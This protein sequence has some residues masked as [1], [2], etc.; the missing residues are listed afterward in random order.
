M[1]NIST[2]KKK[3]STLGI[4]LLASTVALGGC[5]TGGET[6][7]ETE[8]AATGNGQ[9]EAAVDAPEPVKEGYPIATAD[10][11][12]TLKVWAPADNILKYYKDYGEVLAFQEMEKATGVKIEWIHPSAGQLQ[13]P[14]NLMV[15]SRDLPDVIIYPWGNTSFLPGGAQKYVQDGVIIPLSE[16]IDYAP[17]YAKVLEDYPEI[18]K[19]VTDDDGEMNYISLM[20]PELT[21]RTYNGF[22]IRQ[23]WL[24]KLSLPMPRSTDDLYN[25]LKAFQDNDMNGNGKK[26]EY[27][28]STGMDKGI[29]G[30]EKLLYPFGATAGNDAFIQSGGKVIYS[31]MQPEFKEG[32]AYL[33]KLYQEGLLDPEYM[34]N[35]NTKLQQKYT[36]GTVS[37]SYSS[38]GRIASWQPGLKE[39]DA[40]ATLSPIPSLTGPDGS[41]YWL[42]ANTANITNPGVSLAITTANKFPAET[43]RWWNWVFTEAGKTAFNYGKEGVTFEIVDG[44]PQ[45]TEMITNDSQ[46]RTQNEMLSLTAPA[47]GLPTL[48]ELEATRLQKSEAEWNAFE[49]W[50]NNMLDN[51]RIMPPVMFNDSELDVMTSKKPAIDDYQKQM[52]D[53]FITGR[54]SLDAWET[55]FVPQLKKL[56]I[57]EVTAAYQTALDRYNQR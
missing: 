54:T 34:L 30:I 9:A 2:E 43:M 7:P 6:K 31:P 25:V 3:W 51:S 46:G 19:R 32:V 41:G 47:V 8:P 24:D 15:A 39:V 21:M 37:V 23:D 50:G 52:L 26:D 49:T 36:N 29:L 11:P 38:A 12:L 20:T 14:F 28:S 1:L 16:Y 4:V 57:D 22:M 48:N 5:S 33:N 42:E 10:Q 13:E 56:G 35:D 18:K 17:D 45:F 55:E 44:K 53:K 27:F 40:D